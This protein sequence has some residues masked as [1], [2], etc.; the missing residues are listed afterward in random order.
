MSDVAL[1]PLECDALLWL[2]RESG[3]LLSSQVPDV[4]DRDPVFGTTTP[5]VRTFRG[6]ARQGL[7]FETEEDPMD[8]EEPEGERWTSSW[9]LTE[10]GWAMAHRVAAPSAAPVARRLGR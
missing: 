8:P 2:L 1:K 5:G 4:A 9:E 10:A 7:C 6:L 3:S